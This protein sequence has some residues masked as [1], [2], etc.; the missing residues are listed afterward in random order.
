VATAAAPPSNGAQAGIPHVVTPTPRS[1]EDFTARG[2]VLHVERAEPPAAP[3]AQDAARTPEVLAV[4]VPVRPQGLMAAI[5]ARASAIRAAHED[6]GDG[7]LGAI[8]DAVAAGSVDGVGQ[9][10]AAARE[11]LAV[12]NDPDTDPSTLAQVFERDPALTQALLRHANSAAVGGGYASVSSVSSA[13]TRVGMAAARGVVLAYLVNGRLCRPGGPYGA[14]LDD[15]WGHMVRTAPFARAIA[16][17]FG[18]DRDEAFTLGLLH[19]VGKLVIFD[20]LS[21]WRARERR[22]PRLDVSALRLILRAL[23]E[24]VGG[25]LLLEWGLPEGVARA[26]ATHHRDPVPPLPDPLGEVLFV[27][28]RAEH[29]AR[30][31]TPL[32]LDALWATG[33][34]TGR[35]DRVHA[36]LQG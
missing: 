17:A 21:S 9:P 33:A 6:A 30:T 8:L 25:L 16:P 3:S 20:R 11:A 31:G 27:A 29:A 36:V 32:D 12:A 35:I 2:P 10:P 34:L 18:A 1:A 14:M 19:D 15:V 7:D 22:E 13:I 5:G 26:I 23:H 4:A 28:E 24:P